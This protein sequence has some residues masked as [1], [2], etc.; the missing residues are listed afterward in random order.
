VTFLR[1]API[2]TPLGPGFVVY[3]ARGVV[4]ISVRRSERAFID[5]AMRYLRARPE[6]RAPSAATARAVRTAM[7][8]GDGTG[9]DWDFMPPFQRKVLQATTRIRAGDVASYG[10][11]A[12]AIG[13]VGA[14]RAVGTAL[15]RNPIPFL[16]PCHRIVRADGIG[17]YGI[18]GEPRKR[19]LLAREGFLTDTSLRSKK[20]PANGSRGDR[21]VPQKRHAQRTTDVRSPARRSEG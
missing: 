8:R 5:E 14:A 19:A 18:G 20:R 4:M 9:V 13:S 6:R 12:R 7:T 15:A 2:D 11:I 3:T 17:G 16:I 10:D 1:Y 21:S